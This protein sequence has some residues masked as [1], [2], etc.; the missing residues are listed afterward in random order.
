MH[1]IDRLEFLEERRDLDAGKGNGG[2]V[3]RFFCES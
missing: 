2:G 3:S 1:D